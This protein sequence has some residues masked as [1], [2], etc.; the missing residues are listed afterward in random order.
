MELIQLLSHGVCAAVRKLAVSL[1]ASGPEGG[2]A[3]TLRA[4]EL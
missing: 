1:G 2:L 4:L 3:F